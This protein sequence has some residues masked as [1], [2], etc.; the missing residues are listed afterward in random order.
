MADEPEIHIISI[1]PT[2]PQGFGGHEFELTHEDVF[3]CVRCGGYEIV[4]RDPDTG[5]IPECPGAKEADS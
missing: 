4:L 1:T 3:K 5:A 2:H